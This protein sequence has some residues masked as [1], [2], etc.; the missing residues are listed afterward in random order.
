MT[1]PVSRLRS[2]QLDDVDSWLRA[3]LWD[4]KLPAAEAEYIFEIHRCKG[5]FVFDNGD[6]KIL[7]GV[8]EVFEI[9]DASMDTDEETPAEGKI[10]LIGRNLVGV[11]FVKSFQQALN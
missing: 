7:Q 2:G 1:I 8:R 4:S 10:V 5:R 3:V 9:N 11:D 6:V